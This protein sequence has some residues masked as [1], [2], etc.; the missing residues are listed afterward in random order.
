[1]FKRKDV[2]II[3]WMTF[4]TVAAWIGF[5]I[6]HIVVTSTIS[7]ELQLQI[8]AIDPNFDMDTINKLKGREKIEPLYQFNETLASASASTS[9]V[10]DAKPSTDS[11]QSAAV[12]PEA[13]I[14]PSE[15]T[16]PQVSGAP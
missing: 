8:T 11:G 12:T 5:S 9:N 10:A 15:N 1:M 7:E 4:L 2:L 13:S 14:T 6:Y 3:L 16:L